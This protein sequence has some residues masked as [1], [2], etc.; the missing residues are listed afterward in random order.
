MDRRS[1]SPRPGRRRRKRQPR[2]LRGRRRPGRRPEVVGVGLGGRQQAG[3]H[4]RRAADE[5]VISRGGNGH[6]L[7]PAGVGDVDGLVVPGGA[8]GERFGRVGRVDVGLTLAPEELAPVPEL[9]V[10]G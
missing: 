3:L 7:V 4:E 5:L 9:T 2:L 8:L 10:N 6:G 1:R